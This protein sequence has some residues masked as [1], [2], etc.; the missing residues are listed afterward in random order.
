[1]A[2]KQGSTPESIVWEIKRHTRR[3]F[4]AAEKIRS[5][6]EGLQGEAGKRHLN[7]LVEERP[8]L[9][10]F[11]PLWARLDRHPGRARRLIKVVFIVAD[12]RSRLKVAIPPIVLYA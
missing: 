12:V 4:T 10:I 3:K 8:Y 9:T 6:L 5:V 11:G 2:G 1:M 7:R